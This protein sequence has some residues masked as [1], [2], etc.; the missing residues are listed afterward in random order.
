MKK[1]ILFTLAVLTSAAAFAQVRSSV[2][3][4]TVY[5][6]ERYSICRSASI[7]NPLNNYIFTLLQAKPIDGKAP[8][9]QLWLAAHNFGFCPLTNFLNMTV[10]GYNNA[11]IMPREKDMTAWNKNDKAGMDL[12]LNFDGAKVILRLYMRDK[13]PV[14]WGSIMPAKD[15]IVPIRKIRLQF[16]AIVSILAK[17]KKSVAWSKVY[18]RMAITPA[19]TLKQ[20]NKQWKLTPA[21]TYLILQDNKYDGSGPGKGQGPVMIILDHKEV[22]SAN[23]E[24]RNNWT[25]RLHVELKPDF[26]EFKFGLWQQ[27]PVISNKAFA[28]K[29]KKEKAAF[30]R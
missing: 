17:V 12:K 20:Q 21:D 29:F 4:A 10:N 16:S 23:L 30:K 24:M 8:R 9:T 2:Q 13:S 28:E 5:K 22:K 14:L 1:F 15:S 6:Q 26:K 18:D 27:K 11:V 3:K 7:N 25:T 19:R